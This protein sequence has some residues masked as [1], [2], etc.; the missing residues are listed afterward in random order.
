MVDEVVAVS[1]G[2]QQVQV[3]GARGAAL[4]RPQCAA[5]P[6]PGHTQGSSRTCW[7]AACGASPQHHGFARRGRPPDCKRP[8]PGTHPQ[9]ETLRT[10]LAMG[11]D[12][13]IHISVKQQQGQQQQ[14]DLQP[15]AVARLLAAVAEKERPALVLLGK[16]AID[17]DCNQTVRASVGVRVFVCVCIC[18]CACACVCR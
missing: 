2:P 7:H 18:V 12:R 1:A 4:V 10:A 5:A 15:L 6:S 14:P 13:A 16:Q 17:D 9:Q 11:A 8:H 3:R